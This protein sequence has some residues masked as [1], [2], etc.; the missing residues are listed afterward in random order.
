[1]SL[2]RNMYVSF[3]I[4]HPVISEVIILAETQ[5]LLLLTYVRT[6]TSNL[7]LLLLLCVAHFFLYY[8][9][10]NF[11]TDFN[12]ILYLARPFVALKKGIV[13]CDVIIPTPDVIK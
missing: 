10:F 4:F 8:L 12:N 3:S 2:R 1:M 13:H 5:Y 11:P 9:L 7:C 6:D